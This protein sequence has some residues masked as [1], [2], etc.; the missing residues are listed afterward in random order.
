MVQFQTDGVNIILLLFITFT[1]VL[2]CLWLK[3]QWS[4]EQFF[5]LR[6]RVG[7]RGVGVI[8]QTDRVT[9]RK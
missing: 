4:N 6:G 3:D 1:P 8:T 2:S 9:S 7:G 5:F